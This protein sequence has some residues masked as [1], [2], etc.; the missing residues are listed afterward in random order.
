MISK[1]SKQKI[2]CYVDETGQDIGSMFFIVVA[3][4]N[5]KQQEPLRKQLK[6]FEIKAKT[7]K[8][9]FSHAQFKRI[10]EY[11]KLTQQLKPIKIYFIC[12]RKPVIY[13][14]P[15]LR[16]LE[17]AILKQAAKN[18]DTIVYVDGI[19]KKKSRELTNTLRELGIKLRPV[20]SARDQSEPFI[21]LADRWAGCIR[22]A[23]EKHKQEKEIFDQAIKNKHLQE[24]KNTPKHRG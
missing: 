2:Y 23:F 17:K 16:L 19:D 13:F 5:D 14:I 15:M 21:R 10:K 6:Q 1:K 18:Y 4:I 11:L 12:F 7:G 24:I 9:K 22:K 20:R 3:V 8:R